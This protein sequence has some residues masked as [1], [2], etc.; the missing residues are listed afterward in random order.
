LPNIDFEFSGWYVPLCLVLAF[1]LAFILYTKSAPWNSG[2]NKILA[3]IRFVVVA[4]LALLLL[5]PLINHI[6]SQIENPK[7]VIAFDNSKSLEN[8]L[9]SNQIDSIKNLLKEVKSELEKNNY[10]VAIRTLDQKKVEIDSIAITEQ[11]TNLNAL[12][13]DIQSEYENQNLAGV[14]LVSDGNY[15]RGMSPAYFPYNFP[16]HSIGV[17]D[18]T[19]KFDLLIKNVL[20]NKIA[21]EGNKY[22]VLVEV[23]N[24][25]YRTRSTKVNVYHK[26]KVIDSQPVS[27][28]SEKGLA[29]IELEIEASEKGIQNL[30]IVL[31]PLANEKIIANNYR[32]IFVDVIDGKQKILILALAPHPDIKAI[33][34]VIANNQNYEL[35]VFIPGIGQLKSENYD[36]VIAHNC[37]DRFNRTAKYINQF[38]ESEIPIFHIL[39]SKTTVPRIKQRYPDFQ[40]SQKGGQRDQV[41]TAINQKFDLFTISETSRASFLQFPPVDVPFGD[42]RLSPQDKILLYQKV[43]SVTTNKPLLYFSDIDQVKTGFMM[44]AGIWKWRLQEYALHENTDAFDQL[45]LKV[46][47]YMSTKEDKRK[48]KFFAE[49]TEYFENEH[50]VFQAE[51]Y[52][53]IY[54][55]IYGNEIQITITGESG[56]RKEFKF[57]PASQYSKLDASDFTTGIYSYRAQVDLGGKPE[58]VRGK[59]S[60][61]ELQLEAMDQVAQH[62]LLK[63][64]SA[65]TGGKFYDTGSKELIINDLQMFDDKSIVHAIEDAYSVINIKWIL[66]LILLLI[67]TE[68]F[69]RKYNGGY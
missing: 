9:D 11:S 15:N 17:G 61:K 22:P 1:G 39:G 2:T 48:F 54:E 69:A 67:S 66:F 18:T 25:G 3:T 21:Y 13:K 26:G 20:F 47:Q 4:L 57:V 65:N 7:Y 46:I 12:L 51:V 53:D 42:F 33:G 31:E 30:R 38:G 24:Y 45:F 41:L 55:R 8:S 28:S 35:D 36:L 60:V 58:T 56:A 64:I 19:Q 23:V 5:N 29:K 50:V 44:G 40:F 68:W 34:A 52:N 16:V 62:N 59:F 63:Q 37:F 10:E 6:L 49:R 43:G 32:N 14:F 27:F